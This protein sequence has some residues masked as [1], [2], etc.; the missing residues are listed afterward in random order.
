MEICQ[1]KQ[2]QRIVVP[3]NTSVD[4]SQVKVKNLNIGDYVIWHSV[5]HD[6]RKSE[7]H[8]IHL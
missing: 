2:I 7:M 6:S 3:I 4:M 5:A 1:N 8:H